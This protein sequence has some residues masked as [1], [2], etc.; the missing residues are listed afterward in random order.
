MGG[1]L[2]LAA[3]IGCLATLGWLLAGAIGVLTVAM[4]GLAAYLLAWTALVVAAVG[5][6]VPGDL[7]R[8]TL[9]AALA[10]VAAAA[11]FLCR[12]RRRRQPPASIR[13]RARVAPPPGRSR[14]PHAGG[15]GRGR[16]CLPHRRRIPDHAQRL[17]RVD[18]WRRRALCCGTSGMR[19][20]LR[21]RRERPSAQRQPPR[22]RDRPVPDH[23]APALGAV[24]GAP[25]VC[26]ALGEPARRRPSRA[27]PRP[28]SPS[29]C[30][31]WPR[32][33]DAPR[34]SSSTA[35]RS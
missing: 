33:R 13:G 28:D 25:P 4:R 1:G 18:V 3:A 27:P 5:V 21:A 9:T 17:G 31:R 22:L 20:R 19:D 23:D 10:V 24:W 30:V 29:G 26:G 15:R 16:G 35:P 8:S 32:L 7:S 11:S 34:S 12:P 14:R 6:S 2:L